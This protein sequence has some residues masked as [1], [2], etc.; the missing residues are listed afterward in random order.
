MSFPLEIYQHSLG[1]SILFQHRDIRDF[2][3]GQPS[4]RLPALVNYNWALRLEMFWALVRSNVVSFEEYGARKIQNLSD[5]FAKHGIEMGFFRNIS[6]VGLTLI[7]PA[8][9]ESF[10]R[11]EEENSDLRTLQH[12]DRC[13][14]LQHLIIYH[15]ARGDVDF[16]AQAAVLRCPYHE[17]RPDSYGTAYTM[18]LKEN[19]LLRS[20]SIR[21]LDQSRK[22]S[23][24]DHVRRTRYKLAAE[25]LAAKL[26]SA[27]SS[28][29]K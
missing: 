14:S 8:R 12:P 16:Y 22:A 28:V 2:L 25:W 23:F 21:V 19:K 3:D 10:G 15:P 27:L 18:K 13:I 26:K 7:N 5:A 1:T 4:S 24:E 11:T 20:I 17:R 9:L 29:G 6:I